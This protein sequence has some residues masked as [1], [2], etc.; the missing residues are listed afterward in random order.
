MNKY[1]I[2]DD[3]VN[4]QVDIQNNLDSIKKQR[5]NKNLIK[6]D[7]YI[8]NKGRNELI[9]Q[10]NNDIF[11]NN[12]NDNAQTISYKY[13]NI[14]TFEE[15]KLSNTNNIAYNIKNNSIN[16]NNSKNND[17]NNIKEN[18]SLEMDQQYEITKNSNKNNFQ[19]SKIVESNYS[20]NKFN[21]NNISGTN[22]I[23]NEENIS[24]IKKGKIPINHI[25]LKNLSNEIEN[26]RDKI[27]E[28]TD[29]IL[30][31]IKE[32]NE[33]KNKQKLINDN[34][35]KALLLTLNLGFLKPRKTYS[36]Y[37]SSPYLYK[38]I[39]KDIMIKDSL[40]KLEENYIK[41]KYFILEHVSIYIIIIYLCF[42]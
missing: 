37:I 4:Y 19:I 20:I 9:N 31:N 7:P 3:I 18:K 17:L 33:I 38:N 5:N 26:M 42:L 24:Q 8:G 10:N 12:S 41:L 11:P 35:C 16:T 14:K 30:S 36:L 34:Y 21:A 15:N 39:K 13:K 25:E 6:R 29:E 28:K 40:K 32:I 2:N 23:K 1:N 27:K 22:D